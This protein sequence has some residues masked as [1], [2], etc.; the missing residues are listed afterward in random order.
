MQHVYPDLKE[1]YYWGREESMKEY[2]KRFAKWFLARKDLGLINVE[3]GMADPRNVILDLTQYSLDSGPLTLHYYA[4][5]PAIELLAS[6]EQYKYWVPKTHNLE[7]TGAYV[8]TEMGHGSDVSQLQTTAT[9]DAATQEFVVHT[10][11]LEATKFWPGGL[12]KTANHCV[13]YARLLSQGKDHGVQ[14]FIMQIR[15]SK[16]HLPL[17]GINIGDIGPKLGFKSSDQG[18]MTFNQVRMPKSAL[19]DKFINLSVDGTFT[20]STPQAKKL[21]FGGMLNLRSLII[22]TS[23]Y[24]IGIEA[25]IASRYSFKRR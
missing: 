1:Y 21:T 17:A 4:F 6:E 8:Q 11:N 2:Y 25:T 12:G 22:F 20:T 9:Y 7:I 24:F 3:R 18:F 5:L 23:H 16:T 19:L 10:P 13:L 15:D 14:A